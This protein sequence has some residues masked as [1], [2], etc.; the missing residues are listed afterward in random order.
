MYGEPSRR[1]AE[2][3][4]IIGVATKGCD[5]ALD[6]LQRGYLVHIPEISQQAFRGLLGER[7]VSKEAKAPQPIV[8][9]DKDN[10]SSCEL[11]TVIDSRRTAAVNPTSAI[12]PDHHRQLVT[13][14][15][16]RPHVENKTVFGWL[17]P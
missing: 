17:S 15:L 8:K 7:R 1:L 14:K 16:W 13:T 2:Q 3:S 5:I 4:Y 11:A 9:A 6:P 10:A 12:D